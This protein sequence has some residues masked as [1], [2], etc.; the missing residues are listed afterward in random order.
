MVDINEVY[1]AA[2]TWVK[3]YIKQDEDPTEGIPVIRA[4]E[5]G[6]RPLGLYAVVD[7]TNLSPQGFADKKRSYNTTQNELDVEHRFHGSAILS[8]DFYGFGALQAVENIRTTVE[9]EFVTSLFDLAGASIFAQGDI[10]DFTALKDSRF[11]ERARF[12]VSLHLVY[13]NN[14]LVNYIDT[15]EINGR[16][17]KI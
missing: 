11:E 3:Q 14:E 9:F 15:V 6:P 2:V 17:I 13:S 16:S 5:N 12:E 10:I 1:S 7:I 8:L 4:Q